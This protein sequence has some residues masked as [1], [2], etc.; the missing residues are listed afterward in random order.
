MLG[1]IVSSRKVLRKEAIIKVIDSLGIDFRALDQREQKVLINKIHEV[2]SAMN[3][4]DCLGTLIKAVNHIYEFCGMPKI[5]A[6]NMIFDATKLCS[7]SYPP[8]KNLVKEISRRYKVTD[9]VCIEA[10]SHALSSLGIFC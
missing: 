9:R 6:L 7:D 5:I 1:T 2:V 10:L 3:N 4:D 8:V